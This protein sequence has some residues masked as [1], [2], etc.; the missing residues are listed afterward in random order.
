MKP[1]LLLLL[2]FFM[3]LRMFAQQK[4]DDSLLLEYYQNQRFGDAFDYLKR[5]YPEPITDLKIISS[6]AYTSQ[7]AGKL[8]DA[9]GYYQRLYD[10]DS[11][12]MPLLFS[13]GNINIRRGNNAQALV[14]FKKILL[15]DSTNFNVNKQMATL[16]QKMG[17]G[18]DYFGYLKRANQINPADPDVA[19]DL[20]GYYINSNG[21]KKADTVVDYALAADSANFL[22]LQQKALID[23][24]LKKYK[25]TIAIG[26]NLMEQ[27]E[28]SSGLINMMGGSYY[29]LKDYNN[30]I[31]TFKLLED[32]NTASETSYYYTGMSYKALQNQEQ[33]IAYMNKAIRSAISNNVNAYYNEI[34]D[35]YERQNRSKNAIAS[36]QKSLLYDQKPGIT[37]YLL[38]NLYDAKLKN[39]RM[40][41]KYFK[42][43]LASVPSVSQKNYI[44]YSKS[45]VMALAR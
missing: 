20:A 24:H 10:K 41:L 26:K 19:F 5:T 22:L 11:T 40:A 30:C 1:Y 31:S 36:Y 18:K 39:K 7:M 33:A 23:Y 12:S 28:N 38:A 35:S 32:N 3:A 27:G 45:R 13:L 25:E 8:A 37:Y 29:E 14:Y 17:N 21:Y 4:I 34:G 2:L 6:L 16:S 15:R 9:D 43:Y 42:K 44:D